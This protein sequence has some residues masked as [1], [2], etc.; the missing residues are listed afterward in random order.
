MVQHYHLCNGHDMTLIPFEGGKAVFR[1]GKVGTAI[2]CCCECFCNVDDAN[3]TQPDA[4]IVDTDCPCY[5]EHLDITVPFDEYLADGPGQPAFQPNDCRGWKWV[6][7][8]TESTTAGCFC[9]A[10]EVVGTPLP[11][12]QPYI[13]IKLEIGIRCCPNNEHTAG[14]YDGTSR[15]CWLAGPRPLAEEAGSTQG[16]FVTASAFYAAASADLGGA[17]FPDS[18]GDTCLTVDCADLSIVDGDLVGTV[19]VQGGCYLEIEFGNPL[20]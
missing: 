17:C 14:N 7:E 6:L 5:T 8:I 10:D 4:V 3:D 1:G 19:T 13:S 15:L 16:I 12:G 18:G 9:T 11:Q 2:Q 20:P